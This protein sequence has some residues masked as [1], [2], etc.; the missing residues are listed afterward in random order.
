MPYTATFLAFTAAFA[1]MASPAAGQTGKP[2][3][4]HPGAKAERAKGA[5]RTTRVPRTVIG[6]IS[7]DD[8][9]RLIVAHVPDPGVTYRPGVDAHGRSV[10]PADLPGSPRITLPRVF[11]I[12]LQVDLENFLGVVPPGIDT[13]VLLGHLTVRGSQV[14]FNGQPLDD[15]H[16]SFVVA[17]CRRHLRRAP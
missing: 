12:R 5:K 15:P 17:Q 13:D 1:L 11:R 14:Y 2:T 16:R 4:L 6:R 10:K 9:R 8:C 7:P 3:P